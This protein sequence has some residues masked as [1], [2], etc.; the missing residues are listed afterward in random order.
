VNGFGPPLYCRSISEIW[1]SAFA[2]RS[3]IFRFRLQPPAMRP[4]PFGHI[5]LVLHDEIDEPRQYVTLV[6]VHYL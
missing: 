1:K 6:D 5:G 4:P 3:S 2:T